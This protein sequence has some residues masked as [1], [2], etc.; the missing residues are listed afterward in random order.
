MILQERHDIRLV[1]GE[2][3][4]HYVDYICNNPEPNAPLSFLRMKEYGLW[5]I[6][7]SDDMEELGPMLLALSLSNGQLSS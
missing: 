2:Y 6:E 4:Q 5:S 7:E 3:D 1:I